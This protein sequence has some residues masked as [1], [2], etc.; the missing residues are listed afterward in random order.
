LIR[1]EIRKLV[2]RMFVLPGSTKAPGAVAFCGV[3]QS[4]G[5]GWVCAHAAEAL[6]EQGEQTVCMVDANLRAPSLHSYFGFENGFGYADAVSHSCNITE[7]AKRIH[8]GNLWLV[9][10]GGSGSSE[11]GLVNPRKLQDCMQELRGEFDRILI[12]TPSLDA[13][14]DAALIAQSSDGVVLV[15]GSGT[16]RREAAR[17][18][19]QGL[20]AARIPLLGAVLNNRIFPIPASLYWKL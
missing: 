10:A 4:A 2:Q 14:T 17:I 15:V 8:G 7:L 6:A 12:A 5:C 16:T 20:E 1:D 3:D 9:T 19:K 11:N 18:A 13:G